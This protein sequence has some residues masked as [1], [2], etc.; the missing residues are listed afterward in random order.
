MTSSVYLDPEIKYLFNHSF[1]PTRRP[2]LDQ[3][4]MAAVASWSHGVEIDFSGN[5]YTN[6]GGFSYGIIDAAGVYQGYGAVAMPGAFNICVGYLDAPGP[7]NIIVAYAELPNGIS[8]VSCV[9]LAHC[10]YYYQLYN[11]SPPSAAVPVGLPQGLTSG[12]VYDRISLDISRDGQKAAITWAH[13]N[14]AVY[15]EAL[16]FTG[17]G[18]ITGRA[19]LDQAGNLPDIAFRHDPAT[20]TD[21]LHLAY[22]QHFYFG[23]PRTVQQWMGQPTTFVEGYLTFSSV[24]AGS[25]PFSLAGVDREPTGYAGRVDMVNLVLDCPDVSAAP[26]WSYTW[27]E[28]GANRVYMRSFKAGPGA[29]SWTANDGITAPG[30]PAFTP[31]TAPSLAYHPSG[32]SMYAAFAGGPNGFA[33]DQIS[34]IGG[35]V[36]AG[37]YLNVPNNNYATG[38]NPLIS[39]SKNSG[40]DYLYNVFTQE[41]EFGNFSLV[42]KAHPWPLTTTWRTAKPGTVATQEPVIGPNPFENDLAFT[43]PAGQ[44][45]EKWSLHI[46]DMLGKDL[47]RF[48]GNAAAINTG[49]KSAVGR[50]VPGTYF[51]TS[52]DAAGKNKVFKA[53]KK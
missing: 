27:T 51:I 21:Y 13:N 41:D 30:I 17:G 34:D 26:N 7:A 9:E 23:C 5:P 40:G 18:P 48:N 45:E 15:I 8:P 46:T 38:P 49:L 50:L 3:N 43:A 19:Q 14:G 32:L 42:H 12:S 28:T 52:T 20:G 35:L 29:S 37:D 47:F 6:G 24:L 33:A 36:S 2:L 44:E 11:W 39:L 25:S 53:I 1:K 22:F 16:D 4:A 10:N 31:G